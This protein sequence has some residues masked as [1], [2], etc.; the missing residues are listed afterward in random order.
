MGWF[1]LA[2]ILLKIVR[3]IVGYV[4]RQQLLDAGRRAQLADT[5]AETASMAGI[6][7]EVVEA[8]ARKTDAEVIKESEDRGWYRD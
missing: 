7:R 2:L 3:G 8:W 4:E 1:E 6:S 5:L